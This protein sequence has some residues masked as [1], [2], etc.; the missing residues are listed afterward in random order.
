MAHAK[1]VVNVTDK[2]GNPMIGLEVELVDTNAF[3][4]AS[5][6]P[7]TH[8]VAIETTDISGTATFTGLSPAMYY[9]RPRITRP[10]IRIQTMM[11]SGIGILC[12]SAVVDPNGRGTHTTIQSA[13]TALGTG[14]GTVL[15]CAGAYQENLTI[16][17]DTKDLW[18]I[19]ISR[20]CVTIQGPAASPTITVDAAGTGAVDNFRLEHLTIDHSSAQTLLYFN[21][22]AGGTPIHV[23]LLDL[24]FLSGS[25]GIDMGDINGGGEFTLR[26]I[27]MESTVADAGQLEVSDLHITNCKFYCA[28]KGLYISGAS[29][30]TGVR[31]SG[32]RFGGG[33]S[34]ALRIGTG[35][36]IQISN[37]RF[38]TAGT[39]TKGILVGSVIELVIDGCIISVADGIGIDLD[40]VVSA[41]VISNCSLTCASGQAAARVGI[42]AAGYCS[43]INISDCRIKGFESYGIRLETVISTG[44]QQFVIDGVTIKNGEDTHSISIGGWDYGTITGCVLVGTGGANTTYGVY[45]AAGTT[46]VVIVSNVE[47]DHD[48]MT[49]LV[50]GV[51]G[52][53]IGSNTG[54]SG[55]GMGPSPHVAVTLDA[56]ADT[57]LSLSVQE[58]G[59]DTQLANLVFSGPAAGGAAVPTF[60]SLV[61]ADIPA[62]IMR[63]AEHTAIGDGAPHHAA[64]TLAGGSAAELTLA[65]QELTLA[66]VLT[67]TEHTA[68]GDAAPHH[69]KYTGAEAIAAVEAADPLNLAGDVTIAAGKS[70]SVDTIVEITAD[71]GVTVEGVKALDSF[72]EFTEIAKPANPAGNK[73]R[74]YTRDKAGVSTLYYLQD[75]GTEVEIGAGGGGATDHIIDADA[76]TEVHVEKTADVDKVR[77][78][79]AGTERFVLQ[80][81][82]PHLTITGRAEI[83]ETAKVGIGGTSIVTPILAASGSVAERYTAA[84]YGAITATGHDLG[85]GLV[86]GI[87]GSALGQ[88][89]GLST[90]SVFGLYFQA[91]HG[92]ATA[93]PQ[94]TGIQTQVGSNA[95]GVGVITNSKGIFIPAS[96]WI[97]ATP[98]SVVG[99]DI[100]EQGGAGAT[101][102][103]GLR[104]SD[105][106]ATTVYLLEIGAPYLR[107]LGTS[108]VPVANET[109]LYLAEG[110]TPTLRQIKS[111]D[112]AFCSVTSDDT[113][114]AS[115]ALYDIFDQDNYPGATLNTTANVTAKNI[116][117]T[118]TNGRFTVG[119]AG[120]Y[121]ITVTVIPFSISSATFTLEIRDNWVAFFSKACMFTHSAL[122]P[123]AQSITVIRA[124]S[125]TDYINVLVNGTA[126]TMIPGTTMS[127]HK[128]ADITEDKVAIFKN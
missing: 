86:A 111:T 66:A 76:D 45:G 21:S 94:L 69:A 67:P 2:H 30:V 8:I 116:T 17:G 71:A 53:V 123:T 112:M 78:K 120:I 124:L 47:R 63:D 64:V 128:I 88:G 39:A 5:H 24:R 50:N 20:N 27:L 89:T 41:V 28:G 57:L 75:D 22:V 55:S 81:A 121:E 14:G 7:I 31:V 32:C 99:I 3:T 35:N 1:I 29:A 104:I 61:D 77:M 44:G 84:V 65:G 85:A 83:T 119:V 72:L 110:A 25:M 103:Y 96:F 19:G 37:C 36:D 13:I 60:R 42:A 90:Y 26:D 117:H 18:L 58:L 10:D 51:D 102:A 48:G 68:I 73:L 54:G 33:S 127:M 62:A 100:E 118:K 101:T 93:C 109:P 38:L 122:D 70:L 6:D 9:A 106:T 15:I 11:A 46:Y 43:D 87:Y 12:Y 125:A 4:P 91:T 126:L 115:S 114:T 79:V 56:N 80:N 113:S 34:H 92:S 23:D 98:G 52:N 74:L 107:L 59:L 40:S 108:W 95:G 105:Q 82:Y 16:A 97:G 49:N